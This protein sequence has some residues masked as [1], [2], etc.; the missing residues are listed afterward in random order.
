[1]G[2]QSLDSTGC[3]NRPQREGHGGGRP[4]FPAGRLQEMGQALPAKIGLGDQAVPARARPILIGLFPAGRH[5]DPP[6]LELC[7]MLVADMVERCNPVGGKFAR[8][9]QNGIGQ[10]VLDFRQQAVLDHGIQTGHLQSQTNIFNRSLI[11]HD[12]SS[13]SSVTTPFNG[14]SAVVEFYWHFHPDA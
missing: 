7:P 4:H 3:Q 2:L 8:F 13:F 12:I 14:P 11:M 6:V 9:F 5:D 1:M 10:S